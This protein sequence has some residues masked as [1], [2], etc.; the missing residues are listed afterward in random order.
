[1]SKVNFNFTVESEDAATLIEIMNNAERHTISW[2]REESASADALSPATWG[3]VFEKHVAYLK[4]LQ[5]IV[6]ESTTK[7]D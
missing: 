5:K 2:M 7:V 4:R 3:H 1:M 6:A